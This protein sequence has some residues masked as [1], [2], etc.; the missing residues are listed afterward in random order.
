MMLTKKRNDGRGLVN[1]RADEKADIA[2]DW[3]KKGVD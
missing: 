2:E 3:S 1:D